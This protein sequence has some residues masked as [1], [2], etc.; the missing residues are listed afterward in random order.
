MEIPFEYWMGDWCLHVSV[1]IVFFC[2]SVHVI[3]RASALCRYLCKWKLRE[4][5]LCVC[6]CVCVC[7][8]PCGCLYACLCLQRPRT[9][10]DSQL[11]HNTHRQV[12]GLERARAQI[13]EHGLAEQILL[14][15][16]QFLSLSLSLSHSMSVSLLV[17]LYSLFPT[18]PN[19]EGFF[20]I[21]SR[22]CNWSQICPAFCLISSLLCSNRLP[23]PCAW[24]QTASARHMGTSGAQKRQIS[25]CPGC[26]TS[27]VA[28]GDI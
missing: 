10:H 9:S 8:C 14:S 20:V 7:E 4:H 22:K 6:V 16:S 26:L 25:W 28:R 24:P 21:Q 2:A 19:T 12:W 18:V 11:C 23:S 15:L 13:V 5:V 3:V 27:S 17:S 1:I